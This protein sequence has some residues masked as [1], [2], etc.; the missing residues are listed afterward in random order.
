MVNFI[1]NPRLAVLTLPQCFFTGIEIAS[2]II[3]SDRYIQVLLGNID[4]DPLPSSSLVREEISR[5]NV[6]I[7][8]ITISPHLDAY[9]LV[10]R[11]DN[12]STV[13]FNPILLLQIAF[14]NNDSQ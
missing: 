6:D 2:H 3:T 10:Y 8:V 9:A 13:Y 5:F 14:A 11:A 12:P 4:D 1:I 7:D